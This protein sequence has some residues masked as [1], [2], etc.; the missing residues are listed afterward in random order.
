[1]GAP[2]VAQL[3]V[4]I[5]RDVK[6]AGEDAIA[7]M[8]LSVT[9]FV[10]NLW[11]KLAGSDDDRAAI[12]RAVLGTTISCD[13]VRVDASSHVQKLEALARMRSLRVNGDFEDNLM[14]AAAERSE[15]DLLVTWDKGMLAKRVIPTVTPSEAIAEIEA[16]EELAK[17][18]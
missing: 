18:R 15:A 3:N 14:R 16:W 8:G 2:A 4:R 9:D 10:R 6:A 12:E 17:L 5:D 1:M 11:E 7:A 13:E